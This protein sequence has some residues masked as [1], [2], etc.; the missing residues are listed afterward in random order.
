MGI[1][2]PGSVDV[3]DPAAAA[4][5]AKMALALLPII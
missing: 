3:I 4:R 1:F 5:Q 2:V